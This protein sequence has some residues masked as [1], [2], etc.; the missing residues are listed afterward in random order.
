M[1]ALLLAAAVPQESPA[2][3]EIVVSGQLLRLQ[4]SLKTKGKRATG[5]GINRTSGDAAFDRKACET[6]VQCFNQGPRGHDAVSACVHDAMLLYA[7]GRTAAA[8]EDA[9]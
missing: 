8:T 4:V 7:R 2:A 9:N 3:D 5:C 6:T 1:L